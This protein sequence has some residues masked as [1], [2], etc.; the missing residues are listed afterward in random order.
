M[1][2]QQAGIVI[3]QAD[4]QQIHDLETEI[5]DKQLTLAQ[6]TE[7]V[8]Q[9]LHA[10]API[11]K[12]RWDARLAFTRMHNVPWKQVVIEKL[13]FA[14]A[15]EVRRATPTVTRCELK[16]IEHAIPPLWKQ[17]EESETTTVE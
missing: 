12:G 7:S 15:E 1:A 10:K 9:L 5:T 11:E 17:L 13:G 4:L 14:Y 3:K 2:L 6:M 16:I 8:K